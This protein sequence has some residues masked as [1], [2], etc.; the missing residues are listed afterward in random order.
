MPREKMSIQHKGLL[1][2]LILLLIT[3]LLGLWLEQIAV[4][5]GVAV[6]VPA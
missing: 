6:T 2:V 1:L 4:V 3:V 5:H